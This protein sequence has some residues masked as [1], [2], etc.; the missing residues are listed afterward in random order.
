VTGFIVRRFGQAIIVIIGVT[1][2]VFWLEQLAPGNIARTI[3]GPRATLAQLKSF[4]HQYG[5]DLS[6]WRQYLRFLNELI[7]GNLGFSWKANRS[8]DSLVSSELP[9]DAI[10]VGISTVL[11]VIIAVPLGV[12]QA[13]KRNTAYD[14]VG[15]G[16][17][18]ILYS[19]PPYVP[20][21]LAIE[22]VAIHWQIFPTEAPQ[23]SSFGSLLAHPSG[24]VLPI[25]TLTLVIYALF[26][27][28]MRSSTIDTLAQD[29]IRTARAKG[30][31]NAEI[32]RRHVLRN[33]L[34]PVATLVGVSVPQ[35]L[36]AGL[37][38]E[39]LFNFDGIG[40]QYFQSAQ[41]NDFPVLAGITV[42]VG[43]ATVLGNL[44]ADI[45][46]GALDP[47]VRY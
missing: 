23:G 30:L 37:I 33:S 21:I 41:Q 10:L 15:T 8:V 29:Y 26:S 44:M 39:A 13:I 27:R 12:Q 1:L 19:M 16:I 28:Y 25:L 6:F 17:S 40:Y 20:G 11:A 32:V 5:L 18:F 24:L 3:L 47:R 46:Y 7:H 43:A 34:I 4:N 36:T 14:Y 9:R 22:L 42:L 31:S 2:L 45:A 38:T 35:I